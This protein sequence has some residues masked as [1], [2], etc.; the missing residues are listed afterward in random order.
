VD[1]GAYVTVVRPDIAAG[2][3][4]R[5]LR[6]RFK[7]QTVSGETLPILKEVFLTVTLGRRPLK[8]W[9]FVADINNEFILGLDIL[10]A[11]D[12]SVDIGRL[13]LRLAGEEISLWSPG[14]AKDQVMT[15]KCERILM[16]RSESPLEVESSLIEQRLQ[17]H[18]PAEIDIARTSNRR[19]REVPLR[20]SYAVLAHCEPVTLVTPQCYVT[21][22][23]MMQSVEKYQEVPKKET[24]DM[25]VGRL[26][27]RRRDRTLAALRRQ[28]AK[29]RSQSRCDSTKRVTVAGKKTS[30]SAKVAWL[31]RDIARR[32]CT[33]DNVALRNQRGRTC[34]KRPWKGSQCNNGIGGRGLKQKLQGRI[35]IKDPDDILQ[36][37]L[38][39]EQ[40]SN[41]IDVKHFRLQNENR[42]AESLMALRKMQKRT[43]W[44]GRPPP[45][46]KKLQIKEPAL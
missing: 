2:W 7:L 31:M 15:A 17:V 34:K 43:L 33:G 45:K 40:T 29:G 37:S 11:H 5:Q 20:A 25:P 1:T 18:P 9:A 44:K 24:T 46:W 13:T 3:P 22:A 4:E 36:M 10:R 23:G 26:R 42:T 28:K 21:N 35:G 41:G 14:E 12:A 16:V 19:R 8:I 38:R 30:R 32:E 6:Q 39:I 27:K